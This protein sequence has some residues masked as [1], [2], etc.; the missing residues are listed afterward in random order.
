MCKHPLPSLKR[1]VTLALAILIYASVNCGFSGFAGLEI[2]LLIH[3]L[4]HKDAPKQEKS[5]SALFFYIQIY[6][7]RCVSLSRTAKV[8]GLRATRRRRVKKRR[9]FHV[10]KVR[11]HPFYRR[12]AA[13]P[14]ISPCGTFGLHLLGDKRWIHLLRCNISTVISL[15]YLKDIISCTASSA[16]STIESNRLRYFPSSCSSSS[17]GYTGIAQ[18][19]CSR[20]RKTIGEAKPKVL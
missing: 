20:P 12:Q 5:A 16:V 15:A 8:C 4:N 19:Q 10:V 1:N 6:H 2:P 3:V 14:Q 18:V 7:Y 11:M 13:T 9:P 17:R